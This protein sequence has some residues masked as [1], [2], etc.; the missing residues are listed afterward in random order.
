M[1]GHRAVAICYL[2]T[3]PQKARFYPD[4]CQLTVLRWSIY[5]QLWIEIPY[6]ALF[7]FRISHPKPINMIR[8]RGDLNS[9]SSSYLQFPL[10]APEFSSNA[11]YQGEEMPKLQPAQLSGTLHPLSLYWTQRDIKVY[12]NSSHFPWMSKQFPFRSH[13]PSRLQN[14]ILPLLEWDIQTQSRVLFN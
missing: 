13:F 9:R 1:K 4:L 7:L 3:G 12:A 8:N 5:G 6:R 14:I 2:E 10:L 11:K